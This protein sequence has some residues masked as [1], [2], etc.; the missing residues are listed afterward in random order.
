MSTVLRMRPAVHNM[1]SDAVTALRAAYGKMMAITDNRGYRHFA[2]LHGAPQWYC[3]HHQH[4][5]QSAVNME[6]FL[7]WHRAYLYN[8]E[9]AMRD[10]A[11]AATLPWW[12]WTLGP[13]RQSGIPSVFAASKVGSARNPLFSFAIDLPQTRPPIRH[14]TTRSPGHPADLPVAADVAAAMA[15]TDW[16][17]FCDAVEEIHDRVHGWVSGDMGLV[18][19]AAFDP[20]FWSHH[21]MIDRIWAIWQ[22]R[23][24][25]GNI[26][27]GLLDVV[28]APFN[29]RVRDVLNINDLG[30]DYAAAQVAIVGGVS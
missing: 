22:A 8:F 18:Q 13:P 5:A 19:T 1:T 24:G 25:N 6:I 9:L 2:G 3:W 23:N 28:L 15:R 14:A 20:I 12:D 30:Y 11:K 10:Q 29:L 16:N 26:P 17:D 4:N 21:A 27:S 7:P